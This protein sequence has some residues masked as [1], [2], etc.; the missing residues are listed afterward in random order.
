LKILVEQKQDIRIILNCKLL[1]KKSFYFFLA[2]CYLL[3]NQVNGQVD[4]ISF[5]KDSIQV[6]KDPRLDILAQKQAIINKRA[7][8][9]LSTGL[10]KGFR[11]QL[12][13]SNNRNQAF[14]LKYE[15]MTKYP[16]HKAYVVYQAPYFK[17]RIGNFLKRED[18]EKARKLLLKSY[19]SGVYLVE[20]AIEYRP[21]NTTLPMEE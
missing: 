13:S 15:L 6:N 9:Q 10:Y 17:V 11:L 1:M 20:D 16:E 21:T 19:S 4:T 7:Q 12:L 8:S 3:L 18:A 14:K 2:T 5:R